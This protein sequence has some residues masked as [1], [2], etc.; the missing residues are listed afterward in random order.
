M[1]P[2]FTRAGDLEA[3]NVAAWNRAEERWERLGEGLDSDLL[4]GVDAL[5]VIDGTLFA[6]GF[7]K[8]SGGDSL[9]NIA[10]WA[11]WRWEPL[12]SGVDFAV[13]AMAPDRRDLYVVGSFSNAGGKPSPYI[14]LWHD[15]TLSVEYAESPVAGSLS[16]G[17]NPVLT[18][19]VIRY[20]VPYR[21]HVRLSI[22]DMSGREIT[23]LHDGPL[24]PGEHRTGW[25]PA[26]DLPAGT[27]VVRMVMVAVPL[28][29]LVTML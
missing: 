21:D 6:A 20:S 7:F 19:T 11:G 28:S 2:T 8:H 3:A 14:A 1:G 13:Y 25:T 24:P 17:P 9:R 12:G 10:R 5:A 29:P 23:T 22:L 16:S 27:Y 15:P 18:E 26:P 4:P